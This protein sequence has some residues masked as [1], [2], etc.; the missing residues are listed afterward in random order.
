MINKKRKTMN[1]L[2]LVIKLELT[3]K[4]YVLHNLDHPTS[5]PNS[6]NCDPLANF[7]SMFSNFFPHIFQIPN[8]IQKLIIRIS[9]SPSPFSSSKLVYCMKGHP[10][11][12]SSF[13]GCT[14]QCID[15]ARGK[16]SR[17]PVVH[18]CPVVSTPLSFRTVHMPFGTPNE[19][20]I[21]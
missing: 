10:H 12:Y 4:H 19:T 16:N 13:L 15:R 21:F 6:T 17:V 3:K 7:S 9:H 5:F 20:F 8:L 18:Y 14:Q 2:A 11:S 1:L